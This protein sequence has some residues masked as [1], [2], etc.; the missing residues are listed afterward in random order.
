[1]TFICFFLGLPTGIEP[2]LSAYKAVVLPIELRELMAE[3]EGLEPTHRM[4]DTGFQDRG[5]TNYALP[6]QFNYQ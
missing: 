3:G 4:N 5:D 6:F 2:M 1:M